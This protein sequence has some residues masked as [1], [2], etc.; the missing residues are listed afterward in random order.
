[1]TQE[2]VKERIYREAFEAI[3]QLTI[4][5][6]IA[7]ELDS[8]FSDIA[9]TDI[10]YVLEKTDPYRPRAFDNYYSKNKNIVFLYL[11]GEALGVD[12]VKVVEG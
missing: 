3:V 12:L 8:Y 5:K 11:A 7:D 4:P 9:V 2:T 10:G 6:S 1:M